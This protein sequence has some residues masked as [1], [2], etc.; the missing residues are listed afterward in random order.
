MRWSE[1]FIPTVK[2]VPSEAEVASHRLMVRAGLVRRV[3]SGLYDI[4]PLGLVALRKV[5]QIVREEMNR[6]GAVEL[7]MPALQPRELWEESGRWA[8]KELGMLTVKNRQG[9]E[10]ALG[11]T[12]EEVITDLVRREVRSYRDLPRNFYQIQVKFRDEIRPRFGLIRA[13]EFIMK[14]AYSF[15]ADEEGAATNYQAMFEAYTEIFRRCGLD[16]RA[17]E[18][19]TGAMGGKSSHEFMAMAEIGEDT[20]VE[21]SSC[22][23]AA[24]RDLAACGTGDAGKPEGELKEV[25]PVDTPGAR[26]IEQLAEFLGEEPARMVKT[27]IYEGGGKVFAVLVTGNRDISES[28]LRRKLGVAELELASEGTIEKATG[29]HLGFSGPVGLDGVERMIADTAVAGLVNGITGANEKDRHLLN[30]NMGRDYQPDEVCDLS[31]AEDGD[32]CSRCGSPLRLSR[33]IEVGQ[34]FNLGTRYSEALGAMFLD[35]TG[36]ECPAVMGCYGIGVTRTV[37]AIIEQNHDEDGIIWPRE[38]APFSV[39]IVALQ[40]GQAAVLE[41]A[42]AL[43][44]ELARRGIEVLLDDRDRSPGE[45]FKDA[46]LIGMPV[47]VTIGPRGLKQGK[48]EI[49][50]RRGGE[51]LEVAAAE[52]AEAV[53]AVLGN[54]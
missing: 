33:G 6:R 9:A 21:C 1:A 52:A 43:H 40:G 10:F 4:L 30:V 49:R 13:K 24:N 48:V 27:L 29:G 28:K 16:T 38:V 31:L 46:D 15:D 42:S 20:I 41:C 36:K 47:R 11:P 19:D 39:H 8:S 34:V 35:A 54:L 45:K 50:T 7:L 3:A 18:A 2:E 37:A 53:A 32:P 25:A 17:V 23:Y 5:E 14:D 44:D 51:E 12:H 26:T 22:G